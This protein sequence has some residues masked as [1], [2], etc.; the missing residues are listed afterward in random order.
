M[1][2]RSRINLDKD[3]NNFIVPNVWKIIYGIISRAIILMHLQLL[4]HQEQSLIEHAR[5][6]R[7]AL[8][9]YVMCGYKGCDI[10]C[11]EIRGDINC[12]SLPG[13]P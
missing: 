2:Y 10:L 13:I 5:D 11:D 8:G 12:R 7:V 4:F 1:F 3:C 6:L 9:T